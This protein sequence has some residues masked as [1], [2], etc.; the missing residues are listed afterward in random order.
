MRIYAI[1][2]FDNNQGLLK[3][4]EIYDPSTPATGWL[5]INTIIPTN[6]FGFVATSTPGRL[7]VLG[8]VDGNSGNSSALQDIYEPASGW[9]SPAPAPM[10]TA[11]YTLAAVTGPDGLVYALGGLDKVGVPNPVSLTTVEAY[12]PAND[13]WKTTRQLAQMPTPR[14]NLAAVTHP[15]GLIYAIGGTNGSELLPTVDAYDPANNVWNAQKPPP[16]PTGLWPIAAAVDSN[17][18]ICVFGGSA[19]NENLHTTVFTY[20]PTTADAAWQ[21]QAPLIVQRFEPAAATGPDGLVYAIGGVFGEQEL[22]G[23]VE[24]YTYDPCDYIESRIDAVA[25]EID[26]LMTLL[27]DPDTLP[28]QRT[29]IEKA[30]AELKVQRKALLAE[31]QRCQKGAQQ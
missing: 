8:G 9:M 14:G 10:P 25:N 12:D 11:R 27:Q 1:G 5:T 4:I 17:G 6:R 22:N 15:N 26:D 21:L 29:A 30:I 18:R 16:L 19:E 28:K 23:S 13:S 2:G 7:H 31:L 24:V 3:T 20:D